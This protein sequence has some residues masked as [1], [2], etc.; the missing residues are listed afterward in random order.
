[1]YNGTPNNLHTLQEKGS[2]ANTLLWQSVT[3][4]LAPHSCSFVPDFLHTKQK[5]W[6][7]GADLCNGFDLISSFFAHDIKHHKEPWWRLINRPWWRLT[8]EFIIFPR[9]DTKDNSLRIMER[10]NNFLFSQFLVPTAE[11]WRYWSH[12]LLIIHLKKSS[13]YF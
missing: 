9:E 13:N 10:K 12:L 11:P 6:C 8:K 3:R 1:M 7:E 4:H 2:V 5:E